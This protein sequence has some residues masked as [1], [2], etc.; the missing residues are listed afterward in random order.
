MFRPISLGIGIFVMILGLSFFA[1]DHYTTRGRQPNTF[2]VQN[3]KVVSPEPWKPWAYIGA[4]AVIILWTF[5]V[6]KKIAGEG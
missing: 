5:T 6:P 3:G 1:L 4:G 2:G